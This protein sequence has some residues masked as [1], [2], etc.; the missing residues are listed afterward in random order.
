MSDPELTLHKGVIAWFAT[1][2]FALIGGCLLVL[3]ALAAGDHR[4]TVA[5][6][7]RRMWA[8]LGDESPLATTAPRD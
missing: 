5:G 8:W 1:N 4:T 6:W 2:L 3:A 7:R